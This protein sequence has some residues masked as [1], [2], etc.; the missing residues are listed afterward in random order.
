MT[1]AAVTSRTSC[2]VPGETWEMSTSIPSRFI[3]RTTSSPNALRPSS[4]GPRSTSRPSRCCRVGERHVADAQ[5]VIRPERA[6][7]VLDGVAALHSEHAGDPAVLEDP[8]HVIRGRG[9]LEGV[10][11][12]LDHPLRQVDLLQLD[13]GR[14]CSAMAPDG[15]YTLQNWPPT[16]PARSRGMSVWPGSPF[17][18]VVRL[19]VHG[20]RLMRRIAHGRS[21]CPSMSG[22]VDR[23]RYAVARCGSSVAGR[24]GRRAGARRGSPRTRGGGQVVPGRCRI[25]GFPVGQWASVVWG[26]EETDEGTNYALRRSTGLIGTNGSA[27]LRPGLG[28]GVGASRSSWLKIM[29]CWWARRWAVRAR[30]ARSTR[31]LRR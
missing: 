23:T 8:D 1:G 4:S 21:L 11:V 25:F 31:S 7:R 16:I 10:R 24:A 17:P 5:V 26:Y 13:P 6:Q 18:E 22:V 15:T 3:S 12:P 9:Q 14:A 30:A 20:R 2:M 19:Q 27:V 28:L 29:N